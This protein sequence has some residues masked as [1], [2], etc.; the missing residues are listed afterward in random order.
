[1]PYIFILTSEADPICFIHYVSVRNQ[2]RMSF[3]EAEISLI[4][5]RQAAPNEAFD[6][7]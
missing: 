7:R 3:I 2:N 4:A 6:L 5:G 1:M